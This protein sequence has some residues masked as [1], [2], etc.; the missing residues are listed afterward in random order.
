M[1]NVSN[2]EKLIKRLTNWLA[3]QT[4]TNLLFAEIARIRAMSDAEFVKNG[5]TR[6]E[7][8]RRAVS[9]RFYA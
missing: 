6:E 3:L 7:E 2:L 9:S 8:V 1:T 4:E 5:V